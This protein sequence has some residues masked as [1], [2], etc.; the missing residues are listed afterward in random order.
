MCAYH[1]MLALGHA[2][3][4]ICMTASG[5]L[6]VPPNGRTPRVGSN[7]LA[8]AAPVRDGPPFVF[9][10]A[11]SVVAGNRIA[12]ARRTGSLLP[13]GLTADE[14]GRPI[15]EPSP[16]GEP[17]RLLPLGSTPELGSYKGF[18]LAIAVEI[19]AGIL[20]GGGFAARN[21]FDVANHV[22]AAIDVSAFLP[23]ERFFDLMDDYLGTL[24]ATPPR[25][26]G[27]PVVVPGD[28]AYR[29]HANR[30][31]NGIPLSREIVEWLERTCRDLELP[32]A[33]W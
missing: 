30:M 2:M 23:V 18:G 16:A 5:P 31:A 15:L 13:P 20:S 27:P 22:V 19:L 32:A 7:P 12:E 25:T 9:D 6:I 26:G 1:A 10:A 29:L 24:R 4:G 33:R 3:I 17:T 28:R 21:G 11:M 14:E 8:L